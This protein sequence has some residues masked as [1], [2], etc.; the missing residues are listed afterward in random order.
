MTWVWKRLY[1]S[2]LLQIQG[3]CENCGALTHSKKECV[4]RPRKV[5]ARWSNQDIA[6]DEYVQVRF[7]FAISFICC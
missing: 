5:G 7:F 1:A 3:A 4:E 2:N 6:P